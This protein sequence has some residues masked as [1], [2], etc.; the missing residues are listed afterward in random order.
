MR[1]IFSNFWS[2]QFLF[3]ILSNWKLYCME[4]LPNWCFKTQNLQ[5]GNFKESLPRSN[6]DQNYLFENVSN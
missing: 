6:I 4:K 1:A 3:E 5:N 2:I